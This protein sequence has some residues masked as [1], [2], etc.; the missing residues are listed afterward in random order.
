MP[1]A[2]AVDIADDPLAP[3]TILL[4]AGGLVETQDRIDQQRA[5]PTVVSGI[6]GD[7]GTNVKLRGLRSVVRHPP[8]LWADDCVPVGRRANRIGPEFTLAGTDVLDEVVGQISRGGKS[9][10][11]FPFLRGRET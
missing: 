6:P 2:P 3:F 7:L 8:E 11:L 4:V 5:L 10:G 1:A 9:L